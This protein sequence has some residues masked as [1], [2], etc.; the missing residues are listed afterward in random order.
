MDVVATRDRL[1]GEA[2]HLA[3]A[4]DRLSLAAGAPGDLVAGTDVA[5]HLEALALVVQDRPGLDRRLGDDDVVVGV[6][7]ERLRAEIVRGHR[8]SSSRSSVGGSSPA[9]AGGNR[10][11]GPYTYHTRADR[12]RSPAL[13]ALLALR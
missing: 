10:P 13:P 6:E 11:L 3:V 12:N 9:P 5:Q 7:D 1:R 2:D 8:R 4:A